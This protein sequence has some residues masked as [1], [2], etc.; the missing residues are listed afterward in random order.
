MNHITI[1]QLLSAT[2]GR[3]VGFDQNQIEFSSL[4]IDS[5]KV[6]PG[7]IFWAIKGDMFDGHR[8]IGQAI[9][10]GAAAVVVNEDFASHIAVSSITVPLII[11][12]ETIQALKDFAQW[13]RSSFDSFVIGITGSVGK[14]TTRAMVAAVLSEQFETTESPRNFNNQ[15]GLPLSLLGIQSHHEIGVLEMGASHMGEIKELA[16]IASPQ[17]GIVTKIGEAHLDSFGSQQN[18][19][20]AK[21]ELVEALP[22]TGVAILNGDDL[23]VR[24][25]ANRAACST[26]F[27]GEGDN[28]DL[29][30]TNIDVQWNH[31]GFQVGHFRYHLNVVGRHHLTSALCAVAVGREMG[32]SAE[33][34]QKGFNKFQS[35]TRRCQL[36]QI[37]GFEVVDDTYNANPTSMKAAC[38]MIKTWQGAGKR[39]MLVGDM[40][41]LGQETSKYHFELGKRIAK[42]NVDCLFA[43]GN[44]AEHVISGAKQSGFDQSSFANCANIEMMLTK[45]S[46]ISKPGDLIVVK[47]S[48]GM[49]MERVIDW[50]QSQTDSVASNNNQYINRLAIPE[51]AT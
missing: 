34:I 50:L 22:P 25:L 37:A 29:Q 24:S 18:I 32:M 41:E 1:N 17:F 30:A 39:I 35:V 40:L 46:N 2:G 44:Q 8:F 20:Q 31:L 43:I 38:E 10:R 21:G 23:L 42:S 12:K 49:R 48:R 51:V 47:G 7:E 14:T 13:Y 36:Q 11:V 27:V 28:N 3:G 45:L 26:L 19:V 33:S 15:F 6:Q 5:R 16:E 9:Q 4:S